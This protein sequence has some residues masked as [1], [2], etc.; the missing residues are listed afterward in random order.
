MMDRVLLQLRL[1]EGAS[2]VRAY[3]HHRTNG[4]D[5][6]VQGHLGSQEPRNTT[7][8]TIQQT[9]HETFVGGKNRMAV[10]SDWEQRQH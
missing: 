5:F 4:R 3:P 9:S 10:V 8:H 6:L 1:Q 2:N 7:G